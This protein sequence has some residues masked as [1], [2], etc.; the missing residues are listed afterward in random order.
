MGIISNS[1]SHKMENAKEI[2]SLAKFWKW[3]F[4]KPK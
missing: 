3:E 4:S 1:K 2:S